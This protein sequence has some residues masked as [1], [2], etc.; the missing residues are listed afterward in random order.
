MYSIPDTCLTMKLK[1]QQQQQTFSQQTA[2]HL[3]FKPDLNDTSTNFNC[4]C[5]HKCSKHWQFDPEITAISLNLFFFLLNELLKMNIVE[6]HAS[7]LWCD[8]P[9]AFQKIST[10][11]I[12]SLCNLRISQT[13]NSGALNRLYR[14]QLNPIQ[15]WTEG[16][17]YSQKAL[18]EDKRRV[19]RSQLSKMDI[20]NGSNKK[21]ELRLFYHARS[22]FTKMF[23]FLKQK[24]VISW[25]HH[26]RSVL[27]PVLRQTARVR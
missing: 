4:S 21:K 18:R 7:S 23:K 12:V 3:L 9:N 16:P 5:S 27:Y 13:T 2:V 24:E 11:W 10:G 14:N 8:I 25:N 6:A 17:S 20:W 26:D 22:T 1:Q 15:L 19:H